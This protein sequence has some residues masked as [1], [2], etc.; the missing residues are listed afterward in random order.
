VVNNASGDILTTI[1]V[2]TTDVGKGEQPRHLL[3]GTDGQQPHEKLVLCFPSLC[4][5]SPNA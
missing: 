5:F 4:T 3:H 2:K 1:F